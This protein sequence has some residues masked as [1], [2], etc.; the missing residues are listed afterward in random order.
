M[1]KSLALLFILDFNTL[2]GM[3]FFVGIKCRALRTGFLNK[4]LKNILKFIRY[5]SIFFVLLLEY[6]FLLG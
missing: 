2:F 3:N 5:I 4:L 6:C 1:K